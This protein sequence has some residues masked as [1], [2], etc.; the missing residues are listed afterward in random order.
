MDTNTGKGLHSQGGAAKLKPA[1][2]ELIQKWVFI[3]RFWLGLS[4]SALRRQGLVAQLDPNN[5]GVLIV[6]IDGR[7]TGAGPVLGVD[8]IAR[9]LEDG[10]KGCVIM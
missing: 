10:D 5:T 2:E 8:D 9:R 6:S 3:S 1:I 7:P 4:H